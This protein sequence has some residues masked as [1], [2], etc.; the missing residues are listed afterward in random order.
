MKKVISFFIGLT[1]LLAMP[2]HPAQGHPNYPA[3]LPL[4]AKSH[5]TITTVS[6]TAMAEAMGI[7]PADL[8][9]ASIGTSDPEGTGVSDDVLNVFPKEGETFTILSTGLA[10]SAA[11]PDTN[12][13]EVP[14]MGVISDGDKSHQLGGLTNSAGHDL[15]QF[16][17]ELTPPAGTT[18]LSFDF[19][20][21]SEE[22]PDFIDSAFNDVFVAE[23]AAAP[24]TSELMVSGNT[25]V[26]PANIA[27]D[28]DNQLM[29]VNAA[30]GFSE[31]NPNPDTGTTY[32][33]TSG[34]LRATGCLPPEL[35]TGTVV[36][37]LSVTDLGDSLLDTSVFLDNFQWGNPAE[38][39]SGVEQLV[40]D[41]T[42][43]TAAK[44]VGTR[45]SVSALIFDED[46]N[47][48]I[49][50]PVGF[51][52]TGANPT[53]GSGVT[54]ANGR[55]TF[56]YTGNTVGQ[57]VITA[58]ADQ[59][60]DGQQTPGEP[61]AVVSARWISPQQ[62]G[63]ISISNVV[64]GDADGFEF[65]FDG[66]LGLFTLTADQSQSFSD[67]A[68]GKYIIVEAV[69]PDKFWALLSVKCNDAFVPVKKFNQFSGRGVKLSLEAGQTIDCIFTNERV[70]Y[71]Y[72]L[73]EV[74]LPV[75]VKS[76]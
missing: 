33:G 65:G 31:A 44:Q 46:G 69:L 11:D 23:L 55:A 41:L 38:C 58:W 15:V 73:T 18:S 30:F 39:R 37:I 4:T 56:T 50:Q 72:P 32:D 7:A 16:T 66:D 63:T 49:G 25:V 28:P 51:S 22:F 26:A 10:K 20:F 2:G 48:A 54:D 61:F 64:V 45:H 67:L 57:D 52:I 27:F 47:P 3:I 24:F 8:V 17:L 9:K 35:P 75:I 74:Y 34:L 62:T 60:S 14:R 43:E 53:T 40:I 5:N 68:S 6:A 76:P 19:A 59:N 71:Q 12:N 13:D 21:F 1:L 36:L 70:T 42:P 29:S